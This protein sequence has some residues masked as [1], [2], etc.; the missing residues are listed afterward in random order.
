MD[1]DQDGFGD[2]DVEPRIA[3]APN[4]TYSAVNALDCD[5]D[6]PDVSAITHASCPQDTFSD[7][8]S[9]FSVQTPNDEYVAY[10]GDTP[11]VGPED[12]ALGC[13]DWGGRLAAWRHASEMVKVTAEL[14]SLHIYAAYI[15]IEP[16]GDSGWK[17][18][19]ESSMRIEHLQWC[20][21][22]PPLPEGPS[23]RLALVKNGAEYCIGRPE[24]AATV[25]AASE[26]RP[27]EAYAICERNRPYPTDIE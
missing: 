10:Y 6:K 17:W 12:A 13:E 27:G 2:P 25:S 4:C 3:C 20:N 1:A 15:G 7:A 5:D 11:R 24:D 22:E 21:G 19:G 26:Y 8:D 9:Y 14:S 23:D 16:D 18:S